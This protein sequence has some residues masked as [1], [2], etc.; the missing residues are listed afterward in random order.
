MNKTIKIAIAITVIIGVVVGY[1]LLA[2][3]NNNT[4]Q[5]Q[6]NSPSSDI[7]QPASLET[8]PLSDSYVEYSEDAFANTDG[9]RILFFHADWCPQCKALE[10][11]IL[12]ADIPS[13]VTIFEVDYDNSQQLKEKYGI[14]LQTTLVSV[15]T[16]GDVIKKYIAYDEPSWKSVESKLL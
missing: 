14:T 5:A 11:D 7:Q 3:D 9:K 13:D 16:D 12:A 1:L 2:S 15:D 10:Q 6:V 8:E 4:N